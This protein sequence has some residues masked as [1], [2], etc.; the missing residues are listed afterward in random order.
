MRHS[1]IFLFLIISIIGFTQNKNERIT[2][3]V[4]NG[5]LPAIFDSLSE[6][7]GYFFSYNSNLLPDGSKF[8]L[9][10]VD[11]PIDQFVP[12]GVRKYI[13]TYELYQ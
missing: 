11:L 13:E 4:V 2:L 5:E 12:E 8:T 10:S 3:T 7:T 1:L 6:K 9:S